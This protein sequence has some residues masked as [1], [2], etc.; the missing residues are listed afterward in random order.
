MISWARSTP[1][2]VNGARY[3]ENQPKIWRRKFSKNFKTLKTFILN[4]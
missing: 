3:A 4:I 2:S 1:L